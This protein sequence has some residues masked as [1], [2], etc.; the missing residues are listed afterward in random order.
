MAE[1]LTPAPVEVTTLPRP[2]APVLNPGMELISTEQQFPLVR[3]ADA[4]QNRQASEPLASRV[5]ILQDFADGG[6]DAM[7]SGP[8]DI[9]E[10]SFTV[11]DTSPESTPTSSRAEEPPEEGVFTIEETPIDMKAEPS[12][13]PPEVIQVDLPP[14]PEPPQTA[15]AQAGPEPVKAQEVDQAIQAEIDRQLDNYQKANPNMDRQQT[16]ARLEQKAW[17]QLVYMHPDRAQQMAD[18]GHEGA[19]KALDRRDAAIRNAAGAGSAEGATPKQTEA[20]A[21]LARQTEFVVTE[22]ATTTRRIEQIAK[23]STNEEVKKVAKESSA[24][25]EL[26]LL[27]IVQLIDA[28]QESMGL[29]DGQMDALRDLVAEKVGKNPA[30]KKEISTAVTESVRQITAAE[31]P[32]KNEEKPMDLPQL[33]A[34]KDEAPAE[35][36]PKQVEA[37]PA[38]PQLEAPPIQPL[39]LEAP[40]D[41]DPA[42]SLIGNPSFSDEFENGVVIGNA[43]AL[44]PAPAPLVTPAAIAATE[45]INAAG[46]T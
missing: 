31:E 35:E 12:T 37:A 43:A 4:L 22:V 2:E 6:M 34:P 5:N 7:M 20:R 10:G 46:T 16:R 27:A 41:T 25:I 14:P 28:M 21:Q 18:Q 24:A 23:E 44:I 19:K 8:D 39:L 9:I 33:E 32:K 15:E 36:Q 30:K 17:D 3:M 29:S 42:T 40:K 38:I 11:D 45:S 1:G 13:T 26:L